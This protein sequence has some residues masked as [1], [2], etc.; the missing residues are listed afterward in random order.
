MST[1]VQSFGPS[2][3]REKN[4]QSSNQIVA[5]ATRRQRLV[6]PT[7]VMSL[8]GAAGKLDHLPDVVH[9]PL[10]GQ[11][12]TQFSGRDSCQNGFSGVEDGGTSWLGGPQPRLQWCWI[13][14]VTGLLHVPNRIFPSFQAHGGWLGV[15][16][17]S[18]A[19]GRLR[20]A[21]AHKRFPSS[22]EMSAVRKQTRRSC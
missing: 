1:Q 15:R 3:Q 14:C 7:G 20:E 6:S 2:S 17:R 13:A 9:H 19:G 12:D 4:L 11:V 8:A 5:S 21:S 18:P 16:R 10:K 22:S